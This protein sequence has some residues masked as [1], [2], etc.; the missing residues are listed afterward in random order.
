M[1]CKHVDK[2]ANVLIKSAGH[3]WKYSSREKINSFN[4]ILFPVGAGF[5]MK[6]HVWDHIKGFDPAF[7]IGNDDIDLGIRLWLSGH[8][9]IS[10]SE[11][12]IY[13]EFGTLRSKKTIA[14]IFRFYGLRNMLY[15]WSKNL[16]GKT[17]I[18]QVLPFALLL[19]FMAFRFGGVLGLKGVISFLRNFKSV[20]LSRYKVQ[21]LRKIS[22]A[23]IIPMMHRT[24]TLPIQLVTTDFRLFYKLIRQKLMLH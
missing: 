17:I 10:S 9:V 24:G 8:Q 3:R 5:L 2:I 12:T 16:E 19:P 6:R 22:D 20:F 18:K 23:K 15:L 7:F 13:H 21:N 4:Y 14:P 1:R 11:G